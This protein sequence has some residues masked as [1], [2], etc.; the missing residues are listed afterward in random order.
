MIGSAEKESPY[1]LPT[2]V[3]LKPASSDKLEAKW[4]QYMERAGATPRMLTMG[5]AFAMQ[6]GNISW[7][8]SDAAC[9]L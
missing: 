3:P 5:G 7:K 2:R 8:S 9:C 1:H 6:D 4:V